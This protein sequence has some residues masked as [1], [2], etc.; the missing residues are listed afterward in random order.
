[1]MSRRC[2]AF[3]RLAVRSMLALTVGVVGCSG[4]NRDGGS[5]AG[6]AA[7]GADTMCTM[8]V[9]VTTPTGRFAPTGSLTMARYG[10]TTTLLP[11]GKVLVA[12]GSDGTTVLASAELYDPDTGTF[13]LTGSMTVAR[14]DHQATS[15]SNGN[16]LITGGV[17]DMGGAPVLVSAELYDVAAGT[18][19]ATG[20][21]TTARRDHTATLLLNGTVLVAGGWDGSAALAVAGAELFDPS[22]GTF[23]PTSSLTVAR[24]HH[25]ATSLRDGRVLV[26]SGKDTNW[27]PLA[28]AELYDPL[29]GMFVPTSP[30]GQARDWASATLLQNG[31]V[32]IAGGTPELTAELYDP[33]VGG[34][35][36]TGHLLVDRSEHS[37]TLLPDGIVLIAGGVVVTDRCGQPFAPA[38]LYD[39]GAG[40]F[41]ATGNMTVAGAAPNATLLSSGRVLIAGGQVVD[42]QNNYNGTPIPAIASAQ[43]FDE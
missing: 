5:D 10:H 14:L 34:F 16:V 11:N 17:P 28:S 19:T 39:P 33:V 38:E 32:L 9:G 41:T 37:A 29:A 24:S 21:M 22:A 35:S 12:G 13:T 25:T 26:T 40:T 42:W 6:G 43:L 15:L 1:M 20:N 27:N 8:T 18:F 31:T 30:M 4:G 3:A 7:A 2:A 36:P 23:T